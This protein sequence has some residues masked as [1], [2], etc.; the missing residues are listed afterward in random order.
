M[1]SQA[2]LSTIGQLLSSRYNLAAMTSPDETPVRSGRRRRHSRKRRKGGWIV[3][4][5]MSLIAASALGVVGYQFALA[6]RAPK[7][8]ADVPRTQHW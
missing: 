6:F 4:V 1:G 7:T 8:T 3:L 5:L 2:P